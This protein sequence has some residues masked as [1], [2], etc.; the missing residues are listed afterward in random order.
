MNSPRQVDIA[1]AIKAAQSC[2]L[3]VMA[4]RLEWIERDGKLVQTCQVVTSSD[5][6]PAESPVSLG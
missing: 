6:R 1:R 2:G 4:V 3:P 5:E